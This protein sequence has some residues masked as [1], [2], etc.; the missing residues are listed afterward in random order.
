M[1][2]IRL[3]SVDGTILDGYIEGSGS[4]LGN[5]RLVDL[6]NTHTQKR[7]I[8]VA[9]C[10]VVKNSIQML[11][12]PKI[13]ENDR[14]EELL[15]LEDDTTVDEKEVPLDFI[16]NEN[17][18]LSKTISLEDTDYSVNIDQLM[19]AHSLSEFK[20]ERVERVRAQKTTLPID[21]R[22]LMTSNY[23][24]EG[25]ITVPAIAIQRNRMPKDFHVGKRFIAMSKV[26]LR[27]LNSSMN[28]FRF[29]DHLIVNSKLIRSFY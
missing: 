14:G 25:K 4:N 2:R 8:G 26:K 5:V 21:I 19:F 23:L 27:Y 20:G 7:K 16:L 12:Q 11:F 1:Q 18:E 6:L 13:K 3:Y 29:H 24:C 28:Y 22:I 17:L 9:D 10:I 15:F